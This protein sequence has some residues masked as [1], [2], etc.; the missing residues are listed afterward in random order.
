M[1]AGMPANNVMC[2]LIYSFK[3]LTGEEGLLTAFDSAINFQRL[4]KTLTCHMDFLL[5]LDQKKNVEPCNQRHLLMKGPPFND[6]SS[7]F[8]QCHAARR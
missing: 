1:A 7:H 5:V 4:N 3:R 6:Y 8:Y 2:K